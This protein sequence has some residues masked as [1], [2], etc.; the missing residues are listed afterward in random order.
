MTLANVAVQSCLES[1][2]DTSGTVTV[3]TSAVV[4]DYH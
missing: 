2:V 3:W 1:P 4:S